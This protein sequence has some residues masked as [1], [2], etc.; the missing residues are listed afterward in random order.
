MNYFL[1]QILNRQ[2]VDSVVVFPTKGD[3]DFFWKFMDS[4]ELFIVHVVLW[5]IRSFFRWFDKKNSKRENRIA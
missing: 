5:N 1:L 3:K 4:L 2:L